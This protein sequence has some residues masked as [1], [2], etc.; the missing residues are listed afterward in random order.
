MGKAV[1]TYTVIETVDGVRASVVRD[2]ATR[3]IVRVEGTIV[4]APGGG[5]VV[6]A[7][8]NMVGRVGQAVGV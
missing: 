4:D 5:K 6:D 3:A 1:R 8:G 7:S 2:W